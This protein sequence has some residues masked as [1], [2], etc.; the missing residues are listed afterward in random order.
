MK[1]IAEFSTALGFYFDSGIL[2]NKIRLSRILSYTLGCITRIL[3]TFLLSIPVL[4]LYYGSL[5]V[6]LALS[7]L[8]AIFNLIHGVISI[9]G[10]DLIYVTLKWRAPSLI[11]KRTKG[12]SS[13]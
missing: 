10:G 4:N 11:F 2:R 12:G 9:S 1:A 7:P 13:V 5:G 3:I 8:V 6:A